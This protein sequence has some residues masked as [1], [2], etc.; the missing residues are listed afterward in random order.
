MYAVDIAFRGPG[1]ECSIPSLGCE[2]ELLPIE[3]TGERLK[4]RERLRPGACTNNGRVVLERTTDSSFNYS[5][6]RRGASPRAT[7]VPR[8]VGQ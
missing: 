4:C 6:F 2:G 3:A 5:W 8:R 1:R 7:G